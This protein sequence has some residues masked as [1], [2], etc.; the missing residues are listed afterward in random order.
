MHVPITQPTES[1]AGD[2]IFTQPKFHFGQVLEDLKGDKGFVVGMNFDGD[3]WN[4][5]LFY[6]ELLALG[7]ELP[8]SQLAS[9]STTVVAIDSYNYLEG[10]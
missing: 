4:Y 10:S 8:E 7:K 1:V 6:T 5:I 3:N 2:L 9:S